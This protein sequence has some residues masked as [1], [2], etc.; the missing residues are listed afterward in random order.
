[1]KLVKKVL[2]AAVFVAPT[3]NAD[4]LV[5]F[6]D[7]AVIWVKKGAVVESLHPA[8]KLAVPTINAV[9]QICGVHEAVITSG[10][11][12]FEAH[13]KLSTHVYGRAV[14]LR[15]R[16][17]TLEQIACIKRE[18][19]PRLPTAFQHEG[20][21]QLIWETPK[22]HRTNAPHWHLQFVDHAKNTKVAEGQD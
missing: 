12:S 11:D 22:T 7:D 4:T 13:R 21:Y 9:W 17:H 1:M 15:G 2:L 8:I 18:L 14:D 20:R 19:P 5:R 3:A 10:K 6:A 16:T